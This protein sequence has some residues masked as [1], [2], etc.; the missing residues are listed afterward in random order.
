MSLMPCGIL[1]I[2]DTD[3]SPKEI[4]SRMNP[5]NKLN[6]YKIRLILIYFYFEYFSAIAFTSAFMVF[7]NDTGSRTST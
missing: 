6:F 3:V 7:L 2:G 4:L 5:E 1:K